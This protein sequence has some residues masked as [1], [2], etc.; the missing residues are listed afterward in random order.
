MMKKIILIICTVSLSFSAFSQELMTVKQYRE[1]VLDYSQSL[2]QAQENVVASEADIKDAKSNFLPKLDAA[3]EFSYLIND[4]SFDLEG[5]ELKYANWSY[6]FSATA[7]QNVYSGGIV[8]KQVDALKIQNKVAEKSVEQTIENIGYVADL[9][10]WSLATMS[11]FKQAALNYLEIIMQTYTIIKDRYE[12]GLISKNDLL[13]IE[14]RLQDAKYQLSS[15]EKQ[16][17]EASIKVNLLMGVAPDTEVLLADSLMNVEAVIP[18][19]KDLDYAL[20][21]RAEFSI[22]EL[23]IQS[24]FQALKLTKAQYL[25][26]FAVGVL[27]Q[28]ATPLLNFTGDGM[29][30]GVAF[31]QLKVPIF[32]GNSRKH[33]LASVQAKIR[34][35]EYAKQKVTDEINQELSVAWS[36]VTNTYNQIEVA[37]NSLKISEESLDLNTFSYSAGVLTLLDVLS[38]QISWLTA[39]NNLISTKFSFIQAEASYNKAIGNY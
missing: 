24:T 9:N 27:G 18:A 35:S 14:T 19:Y 17:K 36:N 16:Y 6:G 5:M 33:K 4:I 32:A 3:A 21:N 2:K 13:M 26:Q 22:S 34:Q 8:R 31:G 10:Y 7:A 30:T 38:S 39:Y 23:Q 1:K 37:N 15:I 25:P 11:S 12:D 20:G 29:F 28:Y